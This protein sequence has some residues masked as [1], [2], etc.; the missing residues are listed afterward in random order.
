MS[1]DDFRIGFF[2]CWRGATGRKRTCPLLLLPTWCH[3]A[4]GFNGISSGFKMDPIDF[5]GF[6]GDFNGFNG[7]VMG[8]QFHRM[9]VMTWRSSG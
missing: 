1:K 4:D 9:D 8:C 6:K 2:V 3:A 7:N 5:M